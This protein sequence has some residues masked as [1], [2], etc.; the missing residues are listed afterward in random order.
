MEE[1]EYQYKF[2]F[3]DGW[4]RDQKLTKIIPVAELFYPVVGSSCEIIVTHIVSIEEFYA[5]IPSMSLKSIPSLKELQLKMN[6]FNIKSKF[7][8]FNV[9]PSTNFV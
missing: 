3:T 8:P 9:A 1:T 7:V 4:T 5:H 6:S 2:L